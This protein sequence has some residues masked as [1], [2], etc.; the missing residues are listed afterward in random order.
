MG[1]AIS[2]PGHTS[3]SFVIQL[4]IS[5]N[6]RIMDLPWPSN[7]HIGYNVVVITNI[8][9]DN[10][11]PALSIHIIATSWLWSYYWNVCTV[12]CSRTI[13]TSPSIIKTINGMLQTIICREFHIFVQN[14]L[15]HCC[16]DIM[17]AFMYCWF[18]NTKQICN[19]TVFRGRGHPV[20]SNGNSVTQLKWLPYKSSL[21]RKTR[22]QI[23][24][25]N[26]E[27]GFCHSKIFHPLVITKCLFHY[28][29]PPLSRS[30]FLPNSFLM[31]QPK[32]K[33]STQIIWQ[34]SPLFFK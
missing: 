12:H 10:W 15:S 14:I 32:G 19:S 13:R 21:V 4:W 9:E 30:L 8:L 31:R 22:T 34:L 23:I 24:T 20:H 33:P 2:L 6:P 3:F 28:V 17:D 25:Q 26:L 11:I 29:S 16:A 18:S 27:R 1:I 7:F 5:K